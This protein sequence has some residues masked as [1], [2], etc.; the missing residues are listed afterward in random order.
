MT[1][2][3]QTKEDV[4][5]IVKDREIEFVYFQYVE[6]YGK[7]CA[8]LVPASALSEIW[9]DGAG[10]AGFAAGEIGQ[11]PA[12]PDLMAFPDPTTFIQLPWQ[13][14]VGMLT[15]NVYV[16]GEPWPYDPRLILQNVLERARAMGYTFNVGFEPEFQLLEADPENIHAPRRADPY[17]VMLRPCYDVKGITR[18]YEYIRDLSRCLNDLG[19]SNYALDH[20]DANGQFEGNIQ[21]SDALT[22]ADRCV[23]YKYMADT[24]AREH[25]MTATF[26]PKPFV[27]QTGNGLHLT[28]SLWDEKN[29]K[30]LFESDNDPRGLGLSQLAYHFMGGLL[31]HAQAY[32]GLTAPTVNSYKRLRRGTP[33]RRTWVPVNVTYG[34]NNRTQMLRVGGPGRVE[35]RTPDGSCNPY[36]AM[37]ALLACGLDGV[38]RELDPGEPNRDNLYEVPEDELRRRGIGFLPRN[39]FEAINNLEHDE[40]LRKALGRGRDEDYLDYY[41]R[42]KHAEWDSYHEQVS[43]WELENQL[44][45]P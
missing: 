45:F 19:W 12:D 31:D 41:C 14:E 42:V 44:H 37:A 24:V 27:D 10:A 3:P 23:V 30:N 16:E 26:M 25:G 20:E 29:E 40:V 34:G 17:D 8:K 21:F 43:L 5:K 32:I 15:C 1:D 22:T 6:M 11:G 33:E 38:E 35:D 39:L 13:P 7:P 18:Q 9:E 2:K 36:L 28:F 4:L